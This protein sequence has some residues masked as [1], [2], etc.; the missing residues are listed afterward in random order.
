MKKFDMERL[1]STVKNVIATSVHKSGLQGLPVLFIQPPDDLRAISY[2]KS[3]RKILEEVGLK[4]LTIE[5]PK[6]VSS[7]WIEKVVKDADKLGVPTLVQLPVPDYVSESDICK[8]PSRID[9]DRLGDEALLEQAGGKSFDY[10]SPCTVSGIMRII[11][12]YRYT[13]NITGCVRRSDPEY[14]MSGITVTVI[15]RGSLVGRPLSR[16]L[17]DMGA[18]VI[19][20]NSGTSK[21]DLAKYINMSDIVVSAAGKHGVISSDMINDDHKVLIIDAGISFID[22]KLHGDFKYDKETVN[23]ILPE[24]TFTPHIG[25]V[26]PMTVLAV[27]EN[28]MMLL[29]KMG[30]SNEQYSKYITEELKKE[31]DV[32]E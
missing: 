32:N 30:S 18:T 7:D 14:N 21:E 26:G 4:S 22:G 8:I 25:G 12:M 10:L 31:Y 3:K 28:A 9:V 23:D 13:D 6:D 1:R 24:V 15:G 27:A 2:I 17:Q 19:T 20:C 11:G 16:L 29:S 5:I